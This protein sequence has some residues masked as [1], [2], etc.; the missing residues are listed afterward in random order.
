MLRQ[1]PTHLVSLQIGKND[2]EKDHRRLKPPGKLQGSAAFATGS[3]PTT[4]FAAEKGFQQRHERFAVVHD[5]NA[6]AATG[7][8]AFPHRILGL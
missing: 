2:V 4:R 6:P 7:Y 8:R 3:H 1:L 5:E